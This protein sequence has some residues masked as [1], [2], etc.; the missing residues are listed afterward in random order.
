MTDLIVM[1]KNSKVKEEA[2]K[3][4]DYLFTTGM[5]A[6][7]NQDEGFLPVIKEEAQLDYN[8]K[9]A[10]RKAFI[11]LLPSAHFTPLIPRWDEVAEKT[12]A[13]LQK[14]SIWAPSPTRR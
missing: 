1:F 13:A 11:E 5:R 6:K 3:F 14:G 2:W 9:N 10:N 8:A 7:F 12:A 4:L